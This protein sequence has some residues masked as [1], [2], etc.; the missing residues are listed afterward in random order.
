MRRIYYLAALLL[1]AFFIIAILVY[2]ADFPNKHKNGFNRHYLQHAVAPLANIPTEGIIQG[3]SG[4][5]V[6]QFFFSTGDPEKII[7]TNHQL[8]EKKLITL[9]IDAK[10]VI[11]TSFFTEVDSPFIYVYAYNLPA[12]FTGDIH[13][14]TTTKK[15]L[16]PGAFSNAHSLG[17]GTFI[18]RKL[19]TKIPDQFFI[20]ASTNS[21]SI[22]TEDHLSALHYDGGMSTDGL[23]HYDTSTHIFTFLYYYNNSYISFDSILRPAGSGHTIDTFSHFR[24]ELSGKTATT[25]HV[26]TAE[27][28]DH[29]INAASCVYKGNLYVRS[30]LKAD[31]DSDTAYEKNIVIDMYN[32]QTHEYLGSFYL[33]GDPREKINKL[34]IFDDVLLVHCKNQ[35]RAWMLHVTNIRHFESD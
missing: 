9:H 3:I 12:I 24:F 31:N 25:K 7:T 17:K 14:G 19:S 34:A 35:I 23:L 2:T 15:L 5:T 33:P 20:K 30:T 29:M 8:Q 32:L 11:H 22:T 18:L 27:G 21:D 28:P 6:T 16:P 13:T 10:D 26:Y 1:T 4:A